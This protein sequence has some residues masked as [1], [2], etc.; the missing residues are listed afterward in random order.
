MTID[1]STNLHVTNA[2]QAV[3]TRP[4]LAAYDLFVLRFSNRFVWRCP[5]PRL[6]AHYDRHVSANHL[7]VGVG[8]GFFL[9][10]CRFPAARPRLGLLDMNPNSLT[11]AG[12][13]LARYHPEILRADVLAPIDI[14]VPVFSSIALNY[15]LHCLPGTIRDKGEVFRH[16]KPLLAPGGVIFGATLLHAG[17]DRSWPARRLMAFYNAKGIFGNAQDDLDGLRT[18]LIEHLDAVSVGVVGCVALF[19]G[20]A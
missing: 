6:L 15:L 7:D 12:R 20:R 13:R 9:D 18:M 14:D 2:G 4:V 19:T 3:Y 16:L 17:A 10:R 1:V 11:V 5:W 8:T